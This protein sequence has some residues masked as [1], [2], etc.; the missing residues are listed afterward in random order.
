MGGDGNAVGPHSFGLQVEGPLGE[1]F[2]GFPAFGGT[3]ESDAVIGGVFHAEAFKE[4]ANDVG[5]EDAGDEVGV[6]ALGFVGISNDQNEVLI[7][8]LDIAAGVA[9][10][11]EEQNGQEG[12]LNKGTNHRR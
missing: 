9:G 6:E 11:E 4:G 5:L 12:K 10:G 7:G 1:V 2:A 3:G 8:T